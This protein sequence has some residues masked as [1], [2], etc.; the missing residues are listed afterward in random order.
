MTSRLVIA[1]DGPAGSGKSTV[2]RRLAERLRL[3]HLDTG[4]MYRALTLKAL[5]GGV[6]LDDEEALARLAGDTTIEVDGDRVVLDG[7]DVTGEVRTPPVTA[8]VSQLSVHP[9]VRAAMVRRQREHVR[10]TGAVVEGRDIG[11]VVLPD[12]DLKVFLTASPEERARRRAADLRA[13]GVEVE[14]SEVLREITARDRRDS[15]RADSPLRAAEGAAVIDST[16]R[17][18]RSVIE[19]IERLARDVAAR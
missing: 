3:A 8:S 11:T 1:I 14:E 6:P 15:R 7:Q 4:A 18:V 12:A 5:R 13:D 17:D 16:G 19:E 2:A 10:E 9:Q